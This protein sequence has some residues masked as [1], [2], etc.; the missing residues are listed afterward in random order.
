MFEQKK[1]THTHKIRLFLF[2]KNLKVN[3]TN[4]DKEKNELLILITNH[5]SQ[6][7]ERNWLNKN[8]V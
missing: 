1:R 7:R 4:N 5:I 6:I 3:L 2:D 8:K